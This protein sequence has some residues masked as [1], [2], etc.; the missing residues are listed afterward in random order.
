MGVLLNYLQGIVMNGNHCVRPYQSDCTQGIIRAHGVIVAD[1]QNRNIDPLI[2]DKFHI[3]EQPCI[4]GKIDFF[5]VISGQQKAGGVPPVGA[6]RQTGTV[7]CQR[8][9]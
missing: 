3:P 5:P 8:Q 4:L 2:T 6:V 7:D 9:L 1:R